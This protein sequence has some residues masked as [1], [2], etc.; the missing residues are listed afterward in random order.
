MIPSLVAPSEVVFIDE[1]LGVVEE[2][3]EVEDWLAPVVDWVLELLLPQAVTDKTIRNMNIAKIIGLIFFIIAFSFR[4]LSLLCTAGKH[5]MMEC[6]CF[7]SNIWIFLQL[8]LYHICHGITARLFTC[9]EF[10]SFQR[11]LC[12]D[13]LGI[14]PMA[15][16]YYLVFACKNHVMLSHDGSAP[17]G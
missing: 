4:L 12:K 8:K 1:V 9:Q 13:S 5:F 16:G 15:E 14:G 6:S 3:A 17:H 11:P 2:A 7:F 10:R